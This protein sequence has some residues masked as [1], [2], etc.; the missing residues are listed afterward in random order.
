MKLK[1]ILL[2]EDNHDDEALALRAFHQSGVRNPII[3]KRD[4]VQ[5]LEYLCGSATADF[6]NLPELPAVVLLDLNLPKINGH[7]V[8]EGIRRHPRTQHIPVV[9]LTSSR[10]E[11]DLIKSYSLGANSYVRKPVDFTEFVDTF[12]RLAVYWLLLNELPDTKHADCNTLTN[13]LKG[14]NT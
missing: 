1:P 12:S 13:T 7:E 9:I 14:E 3:V 4:G 10:H 6:G 5:A 11:E 8:L 2:V